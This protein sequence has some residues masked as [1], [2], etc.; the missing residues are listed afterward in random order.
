MT[1]DRPATSMESCLANLITAVVGVGGGL[2]VLSWAIWRLVVLGDDGWWLLFVTG[3]FLAGGS[4]WVLHSE[5]GKRLKEIQLDSPPVFDGLAVSDGCVLISGM[6][7][8]LTC[9]Q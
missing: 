7:N 9:F 8:S 4:L 1:N 3:L 5:D 2:F 6:N